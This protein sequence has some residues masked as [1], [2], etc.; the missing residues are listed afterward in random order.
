MQP[1][2]IPAE[3]LQIFSSCHT[4]WAH[5]VQAYP[6]TL[7]PG[8]KALLLCAPAGPVLQLP[9]SA[10]GTLCRR[11]GCRRPFRQALQC[12]LVRPLSDLLPGMS[13]CP[14]ASHLPN[15]L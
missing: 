10:Q 14:E 12:V 7:Y 5:A 11:P 1:S 3:K 9:S 15:D 4:M 2:G 6:L 13:L 8:P